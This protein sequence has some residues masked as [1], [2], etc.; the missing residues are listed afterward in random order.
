MSQLKYRPDIDGLRAVAVLGVLLYHAFPC[1]LPG[2]FIGVDIFFVISGYLISGILYRGV[3]EGNFSFR[4]FYGRR[5][6]R[7][8][9]SLIIVLILCLLYGR[10]LLLPDEYSSLGKQV[11]WGAIFSQNFLYWQESGYFDI[12]ST[13]KPLLHLW[14]LAVEEQFYIF[15]PPLMILIWKSKWP[16]AAIIL[17]LFVA[18]FVLNLVMSFQNQVTDFYLT[19]YRAWE[20]LA[21]ALLAWR[22][23]CRGHDVERPRIAM[24]VLGALL[25][26]IGMV[27]LH[28][29]ES[30]P[31][32]RALFP[33]F[34]TLL[35]IGA[36]SGTWLNRKLLADPRVVWIG[37]ISYPLY[38]FHWPLISFVYVVRGNEPEPFYVIAALI[39]AF[40]LA[41]G[42]FYLFEQKIRQN[43]SRWTVPLLVLVF[44]LIGLYGCAV[45]T[46]LIPPKPLG[47]LGTKIYEAR[48]EKYPVSGFAAVD[49]CHDI[50]I[51]KTGGAGHLTMFVGDSNC[52]MYEARIAR[53]IRDNKGSARGAL[54]VANGGTPPLP[55]VE[56]NHHHPYHLIE[57]MGKSIAG[58]P[59]IDRVVIAARWGMY[60][61]KGHDYF[62]DGQRISIPSVRESVL[63]KFGKMI[64]DLTGSGKKVFVVL[65]TPSARTLSPENLYGRD[66]L[67]AMD[68]NPRVYTQDDFLKRYGAMRDEIALVARKNGAEVIDPLDALAIGGIC[69]AQ[70][71]DGP[72]Y[73]DEGHLRRSF[74]SKHVTYLDA[75]VA[76]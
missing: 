25:L 29:G 73:Q 56:G 14:S 40:A 52:Q 74:I 64:R 44:V 26:G 5:I 10:I 69:L 47:A 58:N 54:F 12:A 9:P 67:G 70:N 17:V 62:L 3:Q 21:G 11:A 43:A 37:I 32:W 35:L 66:F 48:N 13:L 60:F 31:G 41:T 61:D 15:F 18:S 2:G 51:Y 6:R 71:D 1:L 57:A 53:L 38:L 36:G 50:S 39:L 7:L 72:L 45:W 55:E 19:P 23:F 28:Q 22:N 4:D 65:N 59:R 27:F 75:T 8:F 24:A 16:Y 30:Y 76:P 63:K 68:S 49:H 33:V 34:G 20:F 42:T 46:N